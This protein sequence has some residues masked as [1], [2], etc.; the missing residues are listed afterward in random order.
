MIDTVI[1]KL[2]HPS[3]TITNYNAFTPS[4]LGFFAHPYTPFNGCTHLK[5][6]QNAS[7]LDKEQ[8]NYLPRLTLIKRL[9]R[10]SGFVVELKIEFSVPKLIYGN[11]FKEVETSDFETVISTLQHKLYHMSISVDCETLRNADICTVHY[12]KNFCFTDHTTASSLI[13]DIGKVD[14]TRRLD[15]NRTHFRN[16]GRALYYYANSYCLTFYDKVQDLAQKG[17]KSSEKDNDFNL[18]LNIFDEIRRK[19]ACPIEVLRMELRLCDRRKITQVLKSVNCLKMLSFARI[20]DQKVAQTVLLDYWDR[21]H[22]EVRR[23]A[24]LSREPIDLLEAV[25]KLPDLTPQKA[26]SLFAYLE[27]SKTTSERTIHDSLSK[28]F[29]TRTFLR[30]KKLIKE[31]AD[32][33]THDRYTAFD[34]IRSQLLKFEPVKRVRITPELE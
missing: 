19:N 1:L 21:V 8:N 27:L 34:E 17:S 5:A 15:L 13:S 4:C 2:K 6:I 12:G 20:F 11:N 3:F 24:L 32:Q 7:K 26:L 18:N 28:R 29:N 16:D 10:P 25:L 14:L 23:T 31:N 30:L 9:A 22:S 33:V